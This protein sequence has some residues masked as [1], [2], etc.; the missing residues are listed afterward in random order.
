MNLEQARKHSGYVHCA[1]VM[2][3]D[4]KDRIR[5]DEDP[6]NVDMCVKRNFGGDVDAFVEWAH[7]YLANGCGVAG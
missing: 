6:D 2:M 3:R 1:W 5:E 7:D 4:Q